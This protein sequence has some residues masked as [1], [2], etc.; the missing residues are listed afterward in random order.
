MS[1]RIDIRGP[2]GTRVAVLLNLHEEGPETE[3]CIGKSITMT[4]AWTKP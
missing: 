3:L 4:N 1:P 2:K